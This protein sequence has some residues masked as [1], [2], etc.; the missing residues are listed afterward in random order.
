[1]TRPLLVTFLHAFLQFLHHVP[2]SM[3]HCTHLQTRAPRFQRLPKVWRR[4]PFSLAARTAFSDTKSLATSTG[5]TLFTRARC[6]WSTAM[7]FKRRWLIVACSHVF[8]R[9]RALKL[10][11]AVAEL[12]GSTSS[13]LSSSST[14]GRRA[15]ASRLRP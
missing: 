1:M 2:T 12:A 7:L 3:T 14:C 15:R 11:S 13:S 10:R 9:R 8:S 4:E 5:R 6:T